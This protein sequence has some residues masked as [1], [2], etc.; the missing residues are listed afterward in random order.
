MRRP[1]PFRDWLALAAFSTLSVMASGTRAQ[2]DPAPTPTPAPGRGEAPDARLYFNAGARAYAAG[3]FAAAVRAFEEAYRIEPRPGLVFSIAQAYR[4]QYFID[5]AKENLTESIDHY[6]RYLELDP[7]GAR[8]GDTAEA[9]SELEP[10]ASR[11]SPAEVARSPAPPSRPAT[12]LMISSP[13]DDVAI[14]LDGRS[15]GTLPYIAAVTPGVHQV[16]LTAAGYVDYQRDVRVLDGSVVPLDVA[17][18]EK[19]ARLSVVAPDGARIA[20]DGRFRGVSPSAPLTLTPGRHYVTVALNGH[21]A[22]SRELDVAR[23]ESRKLRADLPATAQR[24]AAWVLIGTGAT[25]LLAGGGL[26]IGAVVRENSAKSATIDT[27]ADI[28]TFNGTLSSR[29]ELR[30]AGIVAA[31]SGLA[32]AA[33]GV[34]LFAFDEPRAFAPAKDESAPGRR[35]PT[36]EQSPGLEVS[37]TPWFSP[38]AAGAS[39]KGAF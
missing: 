1:S 31:G 25:A 36:R 6:R 38:S 5:R 33:V 34:F 14:S 20:V 24:T 26:L 2:G 22:Y 3:K 13:V 30:T 39:L 10:L 32:V 9:L 23:D 4:R 12:Q 19:P 11:L 7:D 35:P 28:D 29:N 18:K 15:A 27:A 16:A 17:L 8:R 37:A 21:E